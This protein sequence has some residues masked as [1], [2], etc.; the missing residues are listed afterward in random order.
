MLSR[1]ILESFPAKKTYPDLTGEM[2]SIGSESKADNSVVV[3]ADDDIKNA[4]NRMDLW[5]ETE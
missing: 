4:F 1:V 5:Y 2:T 3:F